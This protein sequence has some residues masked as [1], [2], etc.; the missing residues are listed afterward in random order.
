MSTE[1]RGTRELGN[2]LFRL[3]LRAVNCPKIHRPDG[4][5]A[6]NKPKIY[7]CGEISAREKVSLAGALK[8]SVIL[9]RNEYLGCTVMRT[10]GTR[11][12][13]V[14]DGGFNTEWIHEALRRLKHGESVMIFAE[15]AE[16]DCAALMSLLS[17][18]QIVPIAAQYSRSKY[19][20]FRRHNI[21]VG[22]PI[23]PSGN[24]VMSAEWVNSEIRRIDTAISEIKGV[25]P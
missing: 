7:V 15:S 6:D 18:A 24:S 12:V 4:E 21:M 25:R 2:K 9:S 10:I 11:K 1:G 20:P 14:A 16:Y 19:K 22:A 13:I 8:C 23:L 5:T 3:Y 17:G